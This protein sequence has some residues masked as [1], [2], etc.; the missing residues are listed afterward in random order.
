[1]PAYKY[2]K[3]NGSAAML[4]VNRVFHVCTEM[5]I[6]AFS[7]SLSENKKKS[8]DKMIPLVG[9]EPGPSDYRSNT[10]HAPS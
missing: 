10:L 5:P 2:M 9:I 1:M 7:S 3:E 8:S 6:V 4:A